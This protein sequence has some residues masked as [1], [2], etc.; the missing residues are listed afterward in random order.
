MAR[1][2]LVSARQSV[3]LSY[4]NMYYNEKISKSIFIFTKPE[5]RENWERLMGT[6]NNLQ[7]A[8]VL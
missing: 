8:E 1:N 6:S 2:N 7:I 5:F 3:N 4:L